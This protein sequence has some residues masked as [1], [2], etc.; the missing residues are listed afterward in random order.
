MPEKRFWYTASISFFSLEF[1]F[2]SS[3]KKA[4][5][6]IYFPKEVIHSRALMFWLPLSIASAFFNA[7]EA[8]LVKKFFGHESE[9][10]LLSVPVLYSLPYLAVLAFFVEVPE[11]GPEFWKTLLMQIPL[12]TVAVIYYFKAIKVSPLS[13]TMPYLSFSPAFAIFTGMFILGEVPS[14]GAIAG[15]AVMVFGS[16]ILNMETW[17]ASDMFAPFKAIMREPGSRYMIFSA[18]ILSVSVILGKK[19]LQQSS[20]LFSFLVYFF[21]LHIFLLVALRVTKRISFRALLAHP[22]KGMVI[23]GCVFFEVL[24]HITAISMVQ[25]AVMV[26]VKRLNGLFAVIYGKIL[27]RESHMKARLA[28]AGC[29]F[30]GTVVLA[31]WA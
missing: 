11:I 18:V 19:L 14:S 28:G 15:I 25:A 9:Y 26:A 7:S 3:R 1:P 29:M 27:F 20:V 21:V 2:C 23:G 31:F 4:L 13:L 12:H 16:Y 5:L 24:A 22:G 8:A 17:R 6:L 30:L 10:F